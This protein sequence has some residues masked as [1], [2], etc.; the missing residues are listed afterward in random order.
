MK[1]P[2]IRFFS[3]TDNSNSEPK[4]KSTPK[5]PSITGYISASGKL[6]FPVRSVTQLPFDPDNTSFRIGAQQGKRKIK[7]LFMI[8][9]ESGQAEA[10]QLTKAAKSYTIPLAVILQKGGVDYVNT[11]Y[12]FT[13][14]PFDYEAGVTGYELQLNRD[15]AKA[16]PTGKPRGRKTKQAENAE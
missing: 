10:F 14:K 9:A 8:P 7:S 5:T 12:T 15:T 11:K 6:V 2:E 16:E 13:V 1:A 4:E 3:L